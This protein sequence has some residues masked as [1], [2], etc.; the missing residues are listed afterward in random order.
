MPQ[1]PRIARFCSSRLLG[2]RVWPLAFS[3]QLLTQRAST[4]TIFSEWA[5]VLWQLGPRSSQPLSCSTATFPW[6][7]THSVSRCRASRIGNLGARTTSSAAFEAVHHARASRSYNLINPAIHR[8]GPAASAA[9]RWSPLEQSATH[10]Q[11]AAGSESRTSSRRFEARSDTPGRIV[12][13]V[14]VESRSPGTFWPHVLARGN[15]QVNATMA[16]PG[17][18][19]WRRRTRTTAVSCLARSALLS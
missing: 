17:T 7:P 15:A 3:Q 8:A 2:S 9:G 4:M 18:L 12:R 10:V 11:H 16:I 14:G 5:S 1:Q 6:S 13:A 19:D